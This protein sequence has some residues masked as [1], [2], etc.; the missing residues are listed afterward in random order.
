MPEYLTVTESL[1]RNLIL[2]SLS[3]VCFLGF[4]QDFPEG[5]GLAVQFDFLQTGSPPVGQHEVGL[6]DV[7]FLL[8]LLRFHCLNYD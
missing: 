4:L 1:G 2:K 7:E 8:F 3:I 5:D 6:G